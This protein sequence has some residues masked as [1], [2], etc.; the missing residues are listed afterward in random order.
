MSSRGTKVAAVA[1]VACL[2]AAA[3]VVLGIMWMSSRATAAPHS[4]NMPDAVEGDGFPAIDWDYWKSVNEDVVGWITIPGTTVDYP[5]LKPPK[6]DPG[7]YLTHDIYGNW[8]VYGAVFVDAECKR[9]LESTNA[10]ILGHH[11]D[12]GSMFAP[13][14]NYNSEEYTREHRTV[15][16]QTPKWKKAFNVNAAEIVEGGNPVKRTEFEDEKDFK[17]YLTDR[18]ESCAMTYNEPLSHGYPDWMATLVTC[19]YT[20]FYN[21]RTLAYCW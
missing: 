1:A 12:D 7:Y 17:E 19:S 21:E 15:Q 2:A 10:V 8:N 20:T 18:I 13:I 3:A 11:M 5:I 4:P 6:D 14:S 9:G 16:V